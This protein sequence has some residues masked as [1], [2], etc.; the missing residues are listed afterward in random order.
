MK[1]LE[2]NGMM[3]RTILMGLALSAVSAAN[4]AINLTSLTYSENFDGLGNASAGLF[5]PNNTNKL[6]PGTTGWEGSKIGGGNLTMDFFRASGVG[7]TL[8]AG[9]Y[10]FGNGSETD[11]A[12]GAVASGTRVGGF[13]VEF[14]NLTGAAISRVTISF[15]Q[16]NWR[17]STT[18]QNVFTFGYRTGTAAAANYINGAGFLSESS[19]NLVGPPPLSSSGGLDGNLLANQVARSATLTFTVPVGVGESIYL[20]WLDVD[21]LGS[22]AGLAI[23][24]FSLSATQVNAVPE[25]FTMALGIAGAGVFFRRRLRKA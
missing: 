13:G 24:N 5:T 18:T 9:I 10:A 25:P 12:L 1:I 19:L 14:V 22:D 11:R 17:S 2:G 6:L 7:T 21:D 15:T 3:K 16:E 8:T 23:D 4:A 20:Q